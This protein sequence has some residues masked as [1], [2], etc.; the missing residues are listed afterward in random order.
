MITRRT[1]GQFDSLLVGIALCLSAA[2][3]LG[4]YSATEGWGE[5]TLYF[6]QL[7]RVGLGIL[8]CLTIAAISY[9]VL[10]D[11]AFVWYAGALGLLIWV[12]LFGTVVNNSKSWI[13][14]AGFSFQPS[15]VTKIIVIL[16]LTRYLSE[17]GS[18]YLS[19]RNLAA[20]S[21]ITGIPFTLVLL[22]RDWGTALMYL[23]FT[24]GMA[25]VSGIRLKVLIAAGLVLILLVPAVWFNLKDYQKMRV[26]VTFDPDLDPQG[27]GYQVR[28]SRIAIGSG[29]FFG[30]GIGNG[31]QSRLG[32][33]P[34]SH[35]D[36]IFALLAEETGFLGSLLILLLFLSLLV[37]LISIG[38][39]ARDRTGMLIIAGVASL[40]L[41][42]ILINLGMVLGIL[43]AI[44]IPLPFLSYGGSS[45]I[46]NFMAVGLALNVKI[47]RFYYA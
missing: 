18:S 27:Y 44:G 13:T 37:R 32:F 28:Q 8:V 23:P 2:G 39:Q 34:E 21:L 38:E 4:V 11:Y 7:I 45:I 42:H 19:Y 15:E 31:L 47:R 35:T 36:F 30:R 40:L 9:R 22:Q 29:G 33:V 26:R 12:L 16:A 6:N 17:L 1:F 25:F 5:S 14:I 10:V 43:P 20:I 24:A 41:S 3:V 46:T